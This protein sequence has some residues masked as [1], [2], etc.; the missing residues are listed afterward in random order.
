VGRVTWPRIPATR[1]SARSLVHDG[2]VEGGADRE[3][4]QRRDREKGRAGN[5]SAPDRMGPRDR[6]GRGTRRRSNWRRQVS[7]TGHRARGRE[8]SA[9]QTAADRRGPPVRGG[10][11]ADARHE[12]AE[13]GW[14]GPK[15]L[16]LFPEFP[17]SFSIYFSLGFSIPNSN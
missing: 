6:E 17:N 16:F 12:W 15:W 3:G 8:G 10:R 4:P 14:F 13:L 7:P 2:R 1:A 5:G 11:R 9:G